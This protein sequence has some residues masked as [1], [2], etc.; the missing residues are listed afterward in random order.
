[1]S[2]SKRSSLGSS[3]KRRLGASSPIMSPNDSHRRWICL[4]KLDYVLAYSSSPLREDPLFFP[5][6]VQNPNRHTHTYIYV[7]YIY[8]I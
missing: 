7:I 6:S 5:L 2:D 8:V 4:C 3:F 1:M